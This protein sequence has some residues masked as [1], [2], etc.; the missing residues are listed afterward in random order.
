MTAGVKADFMTTCDFPP[1]NQR[2]HLTSQG[3]EDA[4]A[5]MGRLGKL[6]TDCRSRIERIRIVLTEYEVGWQCAGLRD[7]NSRRRI[8]QPDG[9]VIRSRRQVR[10][11]RRKR[12]GVY[13]IRVPLELPD[14]ISSGHLPQPNGFVPRSKGHMRV[15]RRKRHEVYFPTGRC[16]L[17]QL[18]TGRGCDRQRHEYGR[19]M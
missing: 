18:A 6:E 13:P 2:S 16:R 17:N 5:Y 4:Q 9:M 19:H 14:L 10:V 7:A 8:P 3:I 12:H 15:V 11:I 1:V